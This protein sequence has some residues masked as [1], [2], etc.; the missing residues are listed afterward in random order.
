[1]TTTTRTP[2]GLG[3]AGRRLWRSILDDYE[4]ETH[5]QLTLLEAC[6]IAD[7]LQDLTDAQ[8][9]AELTTTNSRGDTVASPYLVEARQQQV[10]FLRTLASLRLPQGDE[11]DEKRP[12]RRGAARGAY[13]PRAVS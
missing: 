13:G 11:G 5:E 12:Q 4:L 8:A 3:T 7:R 9:G 1:M 2:K 6:R 10:V